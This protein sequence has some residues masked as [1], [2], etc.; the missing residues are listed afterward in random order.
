MQNRF[1][2]K[3]FVMLVLL[4][5]VGVSV[6]ISMAQ[7]DR[8]WGEL[9][10][11]QQQ[12]TNL[13]RDVSRVQE[14]LESLPARAAV[15]GGSATAPNTSGPERA[16]SERTENEPTARD[17]SWAR[18]GVPIVYPKRYTFGSDPRALPG[19][20]EGGELTETM[21]AQLPKITPFL[22]TD[23]YSRRAIDIVVET[24]GAYDPVTL[25]MRGLLAEAWQVSPDGLWFRAKI[26]D[27][28]AFS[29]GQ[30]VTAEDL[31]WTFHDFVMNPKMDTMRYRATL[32]DQVEKVTVIS[33]KVVEWTFKEALFSNQE[34]ALTMWVLPKHFYSQFTEEQLN[35]ATG[36]LM[37]SGAYKLERLDKDN[38]WAPPQPVKLVKNQQY[39]GERR[40]LDVLRFTVVTDEMARITGYRNGESDFV[41]P[42]APQFVALTSEPDWSKENQ[43]LNWINM[44]SGNS[45]IAW[46]CGPRGDT[47]KL[48]PFADKRVRKAM[49]YLLNREKMVQDI[50]SGVGMVSKGVANPASPASPPDLE[51]LPFDVAKG[52][53]LLKEAGWE[54]RDGNGV[55]ENAEG[56]EFIFEFTYSSGGEISTRIATFVKDSYAR[57]GIN[58]QLHPIDW[59]VGDPI[60]KARNFDAITMAWGASAPESDPKQIWHSESIKNMGDNFIQWNNPEA[61]SAINR[62]R[63]ELDRDK[64]MKVWHEFER[65]VAED[66]PYTWIRVQP[67]LRFVKADIG[68]VVM[69]R[70]GPESTEFF[71]LSGGPSLPASAN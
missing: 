62:G 7:F 18:P 25:E 65:I 50:W 6:W 37:G 5:A 42:S 33:P 30:P 69:H 56:N 44:K 13:E 71:R 55:L 38:Q 68:N 14:R 24:L 21:D 47:G 67:Y 17:E 31:R 59:S 27:R 3:D 52:K 35:Q 61:D 34:T 60:R 48:T 54:D 40:P 2:F 41:T 39:W 49:T 10:A 8:Q 16:T 1:G 43:S 22:S 46:N 11:I 23:V 19:F 12:L 45:F 63:R 20:Q 51:P 64:R 4:L 26:H 53:A 70:K 57:A 36:L 9:S 58:V 29:D 66:Q 28:A 32:V 15:G